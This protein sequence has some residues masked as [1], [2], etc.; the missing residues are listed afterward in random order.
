MTTILAI[1]GDGFCMVATDSRIVDID[2]SGVGSASV[3]GDNIKKVVQNGPYLI[4]AAGDVRAI[5]IVS[6]AFNPPIPKVTL[7]GN[8]LDKFFT[9][10]FIPALRKCFEE[11]GYATSANESTKIAEFD[12]Q[13]LVVVNGQAYV[14]GGDYSWASDSNGLYAL[15]SGSSYAMGAMLATVPTKRHNIACKNLLLKALGIATKC[16]PFTGPPY[17][18]LIQERQQIRTRPKK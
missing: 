5:N 17:H 7:K 13:I 2:S 1:Q 3:L 10:E 12:S 11:A 15:G 16:D 18:T 6:F 14:I 4:G 9:N 8:L